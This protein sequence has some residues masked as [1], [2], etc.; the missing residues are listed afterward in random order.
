MQEH[1]GKVGNE[2]FWD[3]VKYLHHIHLDPFDHRDFDED[4]QLVMSNSWAITRKFTN[5][6]LENNVFIS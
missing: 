3:G 1:F 4:D 5:H 6:K 2:L